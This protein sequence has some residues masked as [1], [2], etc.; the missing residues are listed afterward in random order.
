M[1]NSLGIP[2]I[3]FSK[4]NLGKVF[5]GV[6]SEVLEGLLR[7]YEL[8]FRICGYDETLAEFKALI[9]GPRSRAQ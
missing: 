3:L 9:D 4:I 2:F 5:R 1:E 8:D 6:S 7:K